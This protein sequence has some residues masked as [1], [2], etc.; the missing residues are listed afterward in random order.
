[1]NT[2]LMPAIEAGADILHVVYMDPTV[3]EMP[4]ASVGNIVDTMNR[5]VIIG[6]AATMN[7][8]IKT[9]EKVN[10]AIES[11]EAAERERDAGNATASAAVLKATTRIRGANVATKRKLTIHRYHPTD[12]LGGLFTMLSFERDIIRAFIDRGFSD[13]A[14]HDC[15]AS[16]CVLPN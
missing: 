9:A 6:F 11:L 14:H 8:D 1:M 12:D 3:K 5:L 15:Q 13:A 16:G 10:R 4:L 2:P 7:A